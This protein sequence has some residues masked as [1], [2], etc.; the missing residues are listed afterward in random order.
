MYRV[1][2]TEE[3]KSR[4]LNTTVEYLDKYGTGE[5]IMQSDRAQLEAPVMLSQLADEV[6]IFEEED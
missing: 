4:I 6:M 1:K 5:C 3:N 2:L